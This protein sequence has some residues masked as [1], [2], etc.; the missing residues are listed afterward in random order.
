M[1]IAAALVIQSNQITKE[2]LNPNG[3]LYSEDLW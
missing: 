2:D 1:I 3:E